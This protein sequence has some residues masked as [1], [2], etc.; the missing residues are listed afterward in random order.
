[1]AG[2]IID[3]FIADWS[4]EYMNPVMNPYGTSLDISV[5]PKI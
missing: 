1:V 5:S 2:F 4:V 3:M